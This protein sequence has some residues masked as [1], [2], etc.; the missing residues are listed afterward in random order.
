MHTAGR[1]GGRAGGGGEA[2]GG[3]GEHSGDGSS[4]GAHDDAPLDP[5]V[6]LLEQP[7]LN[8]LPALQKPENQVLQWG[9][10]AGRRGPAQ[11]RCVAAVLRV[12]RRRCHPGLH[13]PDRPALATAPGHSQ[14]AAS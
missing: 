2:N 14:W 5:Q 9:G 6:I 7:Y 3:S 13:R 11:L 1:A 10:E 8:F 12:H 4:K